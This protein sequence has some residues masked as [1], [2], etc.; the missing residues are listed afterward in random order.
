MLS[1]KDFKTFLAVTAVATAV[2][3]ALAS[4]L[5]VVVDPYGLY[6]VVDKPGFNQ[7]K[8]QLT[9]Y[10]KE[11]KTANAAA[12]GARSFI[13]GN[14]RAEIGFNPAHPA[15]ADG[16]KPAYN[17]S[18]AG[19]ALGSAREQLAQLAAK[20]QHPAKLVVGVDFLDFLVDPR[21]ATP[22]LEAVR[23]PSAFDRLQWQFDTLFSIDSVLDSVSTV[24]LQHTRFPV[25]M[26]RD[27]FNPFIEYQKYARDDGY[28]PLFQ[29][30]AME[31]AKRF[32]KMPKGL[33]DQSRGSSVDF[34]NFTD[35][36]SEAARQKAEVHIAIY[37][38][39][40]QVLALFES[41]G[42]L[43]LFD[44]WKSE[45]AQRV[46]RVRAAHPGARI[47]LWD[48]SG[49]SAYQCETIPGKGDKASKTRWYW[50][51]GHFK[52]ELGDLVLSRMLEGGAG[53][54]PAEG[55]GTPLRSDTLEQNRARMQRERASCMAQYPALFADAAQLM[56]GQP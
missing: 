7:V 2:G 18:M 12:S 38:Y 14:S 13:I 34:D 25:S 37:P 52:A 55:F 48:F 50:E 44:Q 29:Q 53:A 51:A 32:R 23:M 28:Y 9:R 21:R 1:S 56:G 40:A 47:A 24:R 27:G 42:M 4:A 8:P 22:P 3:A 17:L 6:G 39:H 35:I 45:L 43:P 31:N 30:R 41:A 11:I 36:V 49:Y 5:V 19:H 33:L 54:A 20:G 26:R 10:Q 15:L 16:G 46:E